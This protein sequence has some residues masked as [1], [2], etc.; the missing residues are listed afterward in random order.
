[1]IPAPCER[2]IAPPNAR[3]PTFDTNSCRGA[4]GIL[5]RLLLLRR[6]RLF[7]FVDALRCRC[8]FTCRAYARVRSGAQGR[9]RR[10]ILEPVPGCSRTAAEGIDPGDRRGLAAHLDAAAR[11]RG[12]ARPVAQARDRGRDRRGRPRRGAGRA[13][14]RAS[15][16]ARR[17]APRSSARRT[18][19][20]PPRTGRASTPVQRPHRGEAA[21]LL[22]AAGASGRPQQEAARAEA[23]SSASRPTSWPTPASARRAESSARVDGPTTCEPT[24]RHGRPPVRSASSTASPSR[25]G[26]RR[27]QAQPG[28][29]DGLSVPRRRGLPRLHLHVVQGRADP[30]R[31]DDPGP[32]ADHPPAGGVPGPA[33]L[34]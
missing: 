31:V 4:A 13:W 28:R 16:R 3:L 8:S 19:A 33:G 34:D 30:G 18:S 2:A 10:T 26:S 21:A 32:D 20:P 25:T 29:Y 23:C 9:R 14:S 12:A 1:M 5:D 7:V 22:P 27:D 24:R 17:A 15:T 11:R 6:A